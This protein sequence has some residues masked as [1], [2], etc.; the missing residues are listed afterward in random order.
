MEAA[1]AAA[2]PVPP[3]AAPPSGV[4]FRNPIALR[5]GLSLGS[6]AAMLTFLPF[7]KNGF[8]IWWIL[9][10]FFSVHLYR[11]RTGHLLSLSSGLRM[12]W[13]TGIMTSAVLML[14]F[15]ISVILLAIESGGLVAMYQQQL[16][17]MQFDETNIQQTM[18][19]L[20]NPVGVA[21]GI[22]SVCVLVF[23]IVTFFCTAGGA[24]GAKFG[25]R[26]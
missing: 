11:R 17:S 6:A 5:I 10:G 18:K 13:V 26:N 22:I 4:S 20:S 2:T 24:L 16:R 1:I 21:T 23:G 12:G 8:V 14:L 3:G 7:L 9:A 15:L 25:G 19:V